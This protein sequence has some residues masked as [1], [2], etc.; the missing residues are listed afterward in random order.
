[1]RY[2]VTVSPVLLPGLADRPLGARYFPGGVGRP[3]YFQQRAPADAPAGVRVETLDIDTP[4][5]RRLVG[6]ALLT[7]LYMVGAGVISQDPWLARVGSL[8]SPDLCAF[9]LDPMPGA[10][11]GRVLDVARWLRDALDRVE[12]RGFPKT[13]GASGLHIVVPLA[14]GASW[15]DSRVLCQTIAGHVARAHPEVAT[16]ERTVA[17]RGARVYIDCLQNLRGKTLAAAYSARATAFAGVSIPLR[18]A[19][20]DRAI[21]PRAFTVRT[22]GDRL[23]EV[24]DLW[25]A[26][27]E[28]PGLDVARLGADACRP[29]SGRRRRRGT[30]RPSAP[31]GRSA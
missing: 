4:V 24:G 9:D 26:V 20:L 22:L 6:G 28:A 11:F 7:L 13:S 15:T 14:P 10:S 2:Y 27:R 1:M 23:R 16:V 31:R 21:D 25:R 17:R 8:D 30:H 12:V 18:W 29:P 19:E 3:A 5:R